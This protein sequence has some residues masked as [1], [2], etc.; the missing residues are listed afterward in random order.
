MGRAVITAEQVA[1]AK[2][3]GRLVVPPGAIITQLAK[4]SAAD[5]G[6]QFVDQSQATAGPAPSMTG[7]SPS[8]DLTTR[9][10]QILTV[11]LANGGAGS[12]GPTTAGGRGVKLARQ[13]DARLEPFGYPGPGPEMKVCTGDV[14]TA[15]DGSPVAVGYMTLTEG[16]FPWHLTYDE[17]QVV[18]EGELH[19][20]TSDGV[21]IARP[22]D[23]LYVP[24]DS[25]ITFGTP[26]WTKF[27]YVTFP[28][29]WEDQ[30]S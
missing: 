30:I 12:S 17:V 7:T 10:K 8:D 11:L 29:N 19:I 9:V 26:S 28:A 1:E 15:D 27:V 25:H 13:A 20:G 2:T 16:T 6:V 23:V 5:L 3:A 4:D 22:G 21:K 24:K 18:L 14:V